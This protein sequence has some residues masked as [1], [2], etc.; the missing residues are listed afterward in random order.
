[1]SN[2][3]TVTEAEISDTEEVVE[4]EETEEEVETES[5]DAESAEEDDTS[6]GKV[7]PNQRKIA[8]LAYQQRELKRQNARLMQMLEKQTEKAGK[9]AP[10]KI[11]DFETFDEYLDERDK[12]KASQT[13]AP[14]TEEF[15]GYDMAE[16]ELSRDDLYANG[17]AKHADFAD[18]VGAQNVDI[19]LVMANAIVEIDDTDLQVDT[20]YYLGSNSREANRI[21]KLSPVKQIAE[22]LKISNKIEAKKTS[23]KQPTKAPKPVKPVGGSK[24]S[25]DE[26]QPV[27]DFETFLK[28]RS[29][30]LGRG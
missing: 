15:S 30:Q 24:T 2:E 10:P 6:E 19:T 17:I 25:T 13:V 23:T 14:K 27:E 26:I 4:T 9:V 28:K 16:F 7:D 21:A 11:E 12:W 29:K 20:A 18:V 3:E 5:T 8:E 1:M 22:V